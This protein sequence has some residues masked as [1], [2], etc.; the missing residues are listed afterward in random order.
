MVS[1]TSPPQP[2][3]QYAA[4][5]PASWLALLALVTLGLL[6]FGA[7]GWWLGELELCILGVSSG[8]MV[9]GSGL[10]GDGN[11]PRF[12]AGR[13]LGRV[14]FETSPWPARPGD[15]LTHTLVLSPA[16]PLHTLG[17]RARLVAS[18]LVPR[19]GVTTPPMQTLYEE[20]VQLCDA[21]TLQAGDTLQAIFSIPRDVSASDLPASASL[22]WTITTRV[23]LRGW[24]DWEGVRMVEVCA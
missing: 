13:R 7:W 5:T 1:T 19:E 20:R 23:A 15:A 2:S 17:V 9:G 24:P 18:V 10:F 22:V 3:I 21:R 8:L 12:I 11:L 4:E 6:A 16:R 14:R